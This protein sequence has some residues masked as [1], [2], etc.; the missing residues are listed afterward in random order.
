MGDTA[1]AFTLSRVLMRVQAG[2]GGE[3]GGLRK[4]ASDGFVPA[5]PAAAQGELG[6]PSTVASWLDELPSC[7]QPLCFQLIS[8]CLKQALAMTAKKP[9][10]LCLSPHFLQ[11]WIGMRV[12]RDWE[13]EAC[14]PPL[15]TPQGHR[16][17][18][19]DPCLGLLASVVPGPVP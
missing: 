11:G 3:T 16:G 4:E 6:T 19:V 1:R 15:P 7:L 18:A 13:E 12:E 10:L 5:S 17:R 8:S 9:N 14:P 2:S